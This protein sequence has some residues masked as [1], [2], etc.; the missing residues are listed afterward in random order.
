MRVELESTRVAR[1]RINLR[2][3]SLLFSLS[4]FLPPIASGSCSRN[5]VSLARLLGLVSKFSLCSL[6]QSEHSHTQAEPEEHCFQSSS[7]G[8]RS[9]CERSKHNAWRIACA[10]CSSAFNTTLTDETISRKQSVAGFRSPS[11]S[12]LIPFSRNNRL[13]KHTIE[14][15]S[16]SLASDVCVYDCVCSSSV[17]VAV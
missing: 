17:V 3:E 12:L 2:I 9:Y 5:K 13:T 7:I 11:S 4:L 14:I 10:S 1:S 16:F 15:E 6:S 8:E